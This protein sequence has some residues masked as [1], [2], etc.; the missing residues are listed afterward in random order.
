MRNLINVICLS[1]IFLSVTS[2]KKNIIS[3]EVI[4]NNVNV[5][6]V[7]SGTNKS[8]QTVVIEN[9]KITSVIPFSETDINVSETIIDGKGKY[10]IPALW[11]M[12]THYT[13]SEKT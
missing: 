2:C 8:S 10:I 6:D 9:G 12:H 4:I 5:I 3:G 1:I 11:D 7:V 13:T